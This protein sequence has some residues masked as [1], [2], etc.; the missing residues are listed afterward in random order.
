VDDDVGLLD[1]HL[2]LGAH[3]REQLGG[4]RRLEATGVDQRGA[5]LLVA[6]AVG[7]LQVEVGPRIDAIARDARAVLD[8]RDGAAGD[9]IEERALP[10]VGSADDGEDGGAH[11][12]RVIHPECDAVDDAERPA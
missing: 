8:D 4:R 10:D 2:R 9:A 7:S 5:H 3:R 11:G 6:R 12:A 1:G